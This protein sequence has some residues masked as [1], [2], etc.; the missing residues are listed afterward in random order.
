[1]E[2]ILVLLSI[3]AL[4]I[5][6]PSLAGRLCNVTGSLRTGRICGVCG[7]GTTVECIDFNEL[8]APWLA[9][10][11][12]ILDL[13][14][15][16]DQ[17]VDHVPVMV[18]LVLRLLYM[19]V[20][21]PLP[22][23]FR[24]CDFLRSLRA[25]WQSVSGALLPAFDPLPIP[26]R[27]E[28]LVLIIGGGQFCLLLAPLGSLLGRAL[29]A[30]ALASAHIEHHDIAQL[31]L[32]L[33]LTRSQVLVHAF[34]Q[35]NELELDTTLGLSHGWACIASAHGRLSAATTLFH[36]G[37]ELC[38]LAL[39]LFLLLLQYLLVRLLLLRLLLLYFPLLL[40]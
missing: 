11:L 38:P 29:L 24:D 18:Q 22:D 2:V 16:A 14:I 28:N 25:V 26:V 39:L 37:K 20:L 1:M 32:R 7:R 34:R 8:T 9:P 19:P 13:F 6:S 27:D 33:I 5:V 35:A 21:E 31:R 12:I 40:L 17:L 3:A 4:I 15:S 36:I 23:L 30:F 10:L